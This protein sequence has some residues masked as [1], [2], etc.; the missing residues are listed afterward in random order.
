MACNILQYCALICG[1]WLT[2]LQ[3]SYVVLVTTGLTFWQ[4]LNSQHSPSSPILF[5]LYNLQ[6][7]MLWY[8]LLWFIFL[9]FQSIS[10]C[11]YLPTASVTQTV[12]FEYLRQYSFSQYGALVCGSTF[13]WICHCFLLSYSNYPWHVVLVRHV[14]FTELLV[15]HV[16]FTE[17]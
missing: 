9:I 14:L 3:A 8:V 16:L 6:S 17:L 2:Q 4:E 5:I 1:I 15:R 13:G 12:S 7:S 10:R 11:W